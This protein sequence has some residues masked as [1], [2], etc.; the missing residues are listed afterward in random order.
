MA[1]KAGILLE[2]GTNELEIVEFSIDDGDTPGY[3][4]VNV[5]KVREIIQRTKLRSLVAAPQTVAGMM[6]L[7]EKVLPVLDL[8]QI[9]GQHPNKVADRIVVLEFNR[10]VIAVLV[11]AVSRIHRLSWEQIEAPS[12]VSGGSYITGLVKLEDRIILIL[13]FER[14]IAEMYQGS[15]VM[16]LDAD[17]LSAH[18]GTGK[19]ILV[20]DD[21]SFIRLQICNSLR[22]A[23][24]IVEEA[25]NGEEAWN[26]VSRTLAAGTFDIDVVITDVEMPKMDGLHLVSLIRG[27]EALANLPVYVFS[28][29][30]S[31]DNIKKWEKLSING[32]LSKPDLPKLVDILG[33]CLATTR[34]AA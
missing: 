19:K 13:D 6:M 12:A 28:S 24:Y 33:E 26:Y 5:A 2:S 32:V 4:G 11:N 20:A 23:G 21:S 3:Y 8:G 14:I 25:T 31:E 30:A 17:E 29:L 27:Q 16:A 34:S 15:A 7:R 18:D 1:E 10:V 9:L 22:G